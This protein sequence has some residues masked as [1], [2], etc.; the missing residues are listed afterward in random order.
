MRLA[1]LLLALPLL[2]EGYHAAP[3]PIRKVLDAPLPPLALVSP[4]KDR[5]LLVNREA[6]PSIAVISEPLVKLAGVRV[7]PRSNAERSYTF[8]YVAYT[9]KDLKTG[10]EVKVDLPPGARAGMP[11]WNPSGTRFAFTRETATAVE[12]WLGE[13][14]TGAVRRVDGLRL[15]P[16][17]G[18]AF[19]WMPGGEAL[20][21][22]AVP[23]N[24]GPAPEPGAKA[25]EPRI[26]STT[27][28]VVASSTY[29]TRDVLKTPV[30]MD[31]FDHYTTSQLQLVSAAGGPARP[32]G[33]PGVIDLAG[34]SPDGA[35]LLVSRLHRPY[36]VIRDCSRFPRDVEVWDLQGRVLETV[37]SLPLAE[38]VPIHGV[39]VG[40]R[41]FGWIPTEPA[42]LTWVEALDGGNPATKA[43]F[44]DRVLAEAP[45]AAPVELA[46]TRARFGGMAWFEDGRRALLSDYDED[47][48]WTRT[49][50]L[51]RQGG[52]RL[53]W[54]MSSDERY[55]APG[56]PVYRAL[57][58]GRSVIQV[59]DGAIHLQGAGASPDGDRPFLDRLDLAT[60][61]TERLFRCDRASY[62]R[63]L[64][65]LDVKAGRFLTQRES[66]TDYPN[67]QV[68]TLGRRLKASEGEAAFASAA[69]PCTRFTNP[70]PELAAIQKRL[71]KYKRADGVDLSFT[72]YLPP[73][74]KPG[75]PLPTILWAYPLD[76]AAAGAAGQVSGSD[77][78]FT[79]ISGASAV[80]LALQ[81]YAV[82]MDAA[83]P[84]VGDP[85]TAYDTFLEQDEAS[86]KAAIDKAV[87]L[88]WTD[89]NRVG[90][91]GHS[92]GALMTANF[93]AHSELFRAGVARS[94]AYNHTIRP[95][96]F[97]NERRTLW[98]ARE[99]YLKIS[100]LWN[101]DRI[102]KPLLL[103]HGEM[104]QNPGTVPYQT[105]RLFEA[106][107][108][109]GATA[110][111][112]ML[113]FE[114]HGYQA[115]ESVEHTL[116]ETVD[117]FD[118]YVKNAK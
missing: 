20:L 47:L 46:R 84:V 75:T 1:A 35:R 107:R 38:Q 79:W 113:P 97:Q 67:L 100:P 11:S 62:E 70:V 54:D 18:G 74:A 115:R 36:S 94:G 17:L 22:K 118:R 10:T 13:A 87:E 117:W 114:S 37:A 58:S 77:Q 30:D 4:A 7:N 76:Y 93:M 50:I 78:R 59:V 41:H 71:V 2:A 89:R 52:T 16:A 66:P 86:A 40:R 98:Q 83:M 63:F 28:P 96:G 73:G 33:R 42:T 105:E 101:A 29:E 95:F 109:L 19:T 26:Q 34:P 21:V 64:T 55:R 82:L 9:L 90:V 3:P 103:I 14:A 57:P 15:N 108:G 61:R 65:W 85:K 27:G 49:W 88:G 44:R 91:T 12:L 39:P 102:K 45:G 43:E 6:Y 104:D 111:V 51:E 8:Y 24:R 110:R 31:I 53:L 68:R 25:P 72:L 80:F 60:L 106:L 56:S 99:T 48:H 69:A 32:V 23:E 81:G 112:V 92:H 5:V 116:W